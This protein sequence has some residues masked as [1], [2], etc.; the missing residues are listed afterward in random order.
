MKF[1]TYEDWQ[2]D[3]RDKDERAGAVRWRQE[4]E[5]SRYD[6]RTIRLRLEELREMRSTRDPRQLMFYYDEGI[7]GN[8]GGMGTP[9]LYRQASTGT[10][11][12]ISDYIHE[13]AG[14]LEQLA[15]V[16]SA[17]F[18]RE[19]KLDFFRRVQQA[20]GRSALML[21]GAGSL[22]PFHLGVSSALWEQGVLPEIVSGASAGAITAAILCTHRDDELTELLQPERLRQTFTTLFD[23]EQQHRSDQLSADDVREIIET[24]IPDMTFGDAYEHT[25]RYLNVSVSP[26]EVHQQSRT[27]NPVISPN[28]YIKETL[29]AT[30]AVPGVLPPVRL[31]A[32]SYTGRRIP[33]VKSR[34][35]V[36]GSV[37]DDLPRAR[38]RRVYGCNF[39]ITSQANPMV[40]WALQD[41][42]ASDPISQAVNIG[43]SAYKEWCRATYPFAMRAVRNIY[44]VNVMTRMWFGVM[45][46]DYTADVNIIPRK[47]FLDPTRVLAKLPPEQSMSLVEEGRNASWRHLERISNC[48]LVGRRLHHIIEGLETP[49]S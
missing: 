49:A 27:L 20:F 13:L 29:M 39:F 11:Q 22:G 9:S 37:T 40:L 25:G 4:E 16:D 47:R 35:W 28:V 36:D 44:P 6:Y 19:R 5:S 48:T 17:T 32:R 23:H 1:S 42:N 12:L 46:Q 43:Q 24:W 34:Q 8:T 15:E 3:A 30:S 41:P 38:L 2:F 31:A 33:Y 14:G 26:S 7:H 21:S 45:T 18:S 10:K